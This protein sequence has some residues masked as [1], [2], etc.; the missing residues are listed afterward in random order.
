MRALWEEAKIALLLFAVVGGLGLLA[1]WLL[2]GGKG[3]GDVFGDTLQGASDIAKGAPSAIGSWWRGENEGT[4]KTDAQMRAEAAAL[5][6]ARGLA[7]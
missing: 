1:W 3:L 7:R 4:Y 6:S 2:F 5:L